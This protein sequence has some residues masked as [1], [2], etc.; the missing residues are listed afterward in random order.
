MNDP[1]LMANF[2][3]TFAKELVGKPNVEVLYDRNQEFIQKIH[4]PKQFPANYIYTA[5]G[6][7]QTYW[8]G[9]RSIDKIIADYTK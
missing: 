1:A 9:S 5:E 3:E 7:L 6:K 8:D 2:L 4:I